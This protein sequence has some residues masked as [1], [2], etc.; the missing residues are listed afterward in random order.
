MTGSPV[1]FNNKLFWSRNSGAGE[2]SS[3]DS[4]A[5]STVFVKEIIGFASMG[6]YSLRFH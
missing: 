4:C 3:P 2:P 1:A 5:A 6:R